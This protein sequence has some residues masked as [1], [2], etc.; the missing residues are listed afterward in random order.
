M[1]DDFEGPTAAGAV[2][3]SAV[4]AQSAR[5]MNAHAE[6]ERASIEQAGAGAE[7]A[8]VLTTTD[9][10]FN[11]L[12][13][14]LPTGNP[15]VIGRLALM[16]S[17][18]CDE[19]DLTIDPDTIRTLAAQLVLEGVDPDSDPRAHAKRKWCSLV[20]PGDGIIDQYG[21]L[22]VVF[23]AQSG[24]SIRQGQWVE[25]NAGIPTIVRGWSVDGWG[26]V[27]AERYRNGYDEVDVVERLWPTQ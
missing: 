16:I 20:V 14:S 25:I 5:V 10:K 15:A 21:V 2:S 4:G 1:S 8:R 22:R 12:A 13:A 6:E 3:W 17:A 26:D 24:A 7:V 11:A 18:A 23:H 19:R 27:I 9:D